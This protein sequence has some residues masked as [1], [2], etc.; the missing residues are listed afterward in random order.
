MGLACWMKGLKP[1]VCSEFA[2]LCCGDTAWT[3]KHCVSTKDSRKGLFKMIN[4]EGSRFVYQLSVRKKPQ[5][6]GSVFRSVLSVY[7]VFI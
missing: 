3:L 7:L 1:A 4:C 2:C 6:S 5:N